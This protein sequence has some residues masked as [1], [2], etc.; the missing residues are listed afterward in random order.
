V[1]GSC[2]P[3]RVTFP[4]RTVDCG[5]FI[6]SQLASPN[7]RER[8]IWSTFGHATPIIMGGRNLGSPPSGK[9]DDGSRPGDNIRA[10]GTSQKWSYPGMPPDSG[11]I[12]RGCPLVGGTIC[13]NVVS[14]VAK[15]VLRRVEVVFRFVSPC[16]LNPEP[17]TLDPEPRTLQPPRHGVDRGEGFCAAPPRSRWA[18]LQPSG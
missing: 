14:R 1:P 16:T 11:G 12:P 6:T 10:N 17:C 3:G 13:P 2:F 5:P 15:N 7:Q 18:E 8:P 9:S 4:Y